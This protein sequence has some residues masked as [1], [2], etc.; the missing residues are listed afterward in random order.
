MRLA[1]K[2]ARNKS[3]SGCREEGF[4]FDEVEVGVE[5]V[6]DLGEDTCPINGVDSGEAV[7]RIDFGVCEKSFDEVLCS[8][9]SLVL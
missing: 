5:V 3:N 8:T 2:P 7:G 9:V 1:K 6:C 4:L